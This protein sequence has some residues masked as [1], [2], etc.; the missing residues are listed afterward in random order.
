MLGVEDMHLCLIP[1]LLLYMVLMP[2]LLVLLH[3]PL[4]TTPSVGGPA[5]HDTI[6][7]KDP[8]FYHSCASVIRGRYKPRDTRISR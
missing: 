5:V 2:L 7:K 3:F 8:R 4:D 6:Y 1:L